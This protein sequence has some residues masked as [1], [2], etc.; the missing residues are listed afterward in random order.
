MARVLV[1]TQQLNEL[2]TPLEELFADKVSDVFVEAAEQ[3]R[4]RGSSDVAAH[5]YFLAG[6]YDLLLALINRQLASDMVDGIN[7][8][9][10]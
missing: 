6:R 3:A 9:Y 2:N 1:D 4:I 8:M 7:H 10:V 5:L